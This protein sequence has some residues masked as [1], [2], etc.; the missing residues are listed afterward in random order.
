MSD[1]VQQQQSQQQGQQMTVS[2]F[3]LAQR[4][5]IDTVIANYEN[6][7]SQMAQAVERLAKE[8]EELKKTAKPENK[9]PEPAAD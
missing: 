1:Q 7:I 6:N 3:L 2:D 4:K 9:N 5:M 8:N